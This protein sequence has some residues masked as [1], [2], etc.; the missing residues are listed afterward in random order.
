[1]NYLYLKLIFASLICLV[2]INSYAALISYDLLAADSS[3]Q[4]NYTNPLNDAFSSTEDGFQIYQRHIDTDVPNALLDNSDIATSDNFGVITSSNSHAF[5]GI[6]DTVNSD[7]PSD[8]AKAYWQV[9]ITNLSTI[10]L[11]MEIAAMGDFES[12]DGFIWRYQIDK[13]PFTTLFQGISDEDTTQSYRLEDNSLKTLND[14]MTVNAQLLSNKFQAFSSPH[15]G[16]GKLLRLEL[17]ANTNGGNE[18][19]AFQNV[20]IQGQSTITAVNEPQ[21]Y[22]LLLLATVWLFL[23]SPFSQSIAV[24][25]KPAL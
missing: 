1:M 24:Q 11:L 22:T 17:I 5:F 18:A 15:L 8:D 16:V 12:N 14:P 13:N 2:T 25:R 9:D 19:I 21:T 3:V 23:K 7:N 4:V 20:F 6:A 10:T